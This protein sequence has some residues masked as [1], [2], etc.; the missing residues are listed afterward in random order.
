MRSRVGRAGRTATVPAAV[1]VV[2]ITLAAPARTVVVRHDRALSATVE[3]AEPYDFVGRVGSASGTLIAPR[4][5]LTA[6]HVVENMT[7]FGFRA[8]FGDREV[9]VERTF[10]HPEGESLAGTSRR[11]HDVAL[12]RL[13]EPLE[14]EPAVLHEGRGELAQ[15]VT[16]VGVGRAGTAESGP[17][18]RDGRRR[19]VTNKV[20]DVDDRWLKVVFNRPPGGTE[21]EGVGG[22]GDSGGPALLTVHGGPEVAGVSSWADALDAEDHAEAAYGTFEGYARVS[23]YVDWIRGVMAAVE[24]GS[25]ADDEGPRPPVS[26]VPAA[27]GFPQ[28]PVGRHAEAFF[29][30]WEEG[31]FEG[32]RRFS[33]EHRSQELLTRRD[34]ATLGRSLVGL[35][36]EL[37][38]LRIEETAFSRDGSLAIRTTSDAVGEVIFEL[39]TDPSPPHRLASIGVAY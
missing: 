35:R 34:A 22:P 26:I 14:I 15:E 7:P 8:R 11:T 10:V 1:L 29:A 3:L 16:I 19:A 39:A 31:S 24:A 17:E 25:P 18:I 5:V 27:K 20:L 23:S 33:A 6:A 32:F 30:A 12:L 38:P 2:L 4:W 21:L 13:A 37:G 9:G 36:E 28:T